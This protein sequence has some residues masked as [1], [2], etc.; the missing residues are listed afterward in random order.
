MRGFFKLTKPNIK[1]IFFF[2]M[3]SSALASLIALLLS[4]GDV[5]RSFLWSGPTAG[6]FPDFYQS[7]FYI[8]DPGA[9]YPTGVY[10]LL[11][12]IR[13]FFPYPTK[14]NW[15][16]FSVTPMGVIL[17]F[18][19][20][21]FI[22]LA[23]WLLMYRKYQGK[24]IEKAVFSLLLVLSTPF[25]YGIERGNLF[26]FVAVLI[27]CFVFGFD[28]PN[29]IIRELS[30]IAL[31]V[32]AMFKIYPAIFGILLLNKKHFH[33]A[34][35]CA[36]YGILLFFLPFLITDGL[37]GIVYMFQN[38]DKHIKNTLP[39]FAYAYR[40]DMSNTFGSIGTLLFNKG[41]AWRTIG[42]LVGYVYTA[43]A[44]IL[45]FYIRPYWKKM[46]LISTV[47]IL[48]QSFA[49]PYTILYM[50]PALIVFMNDRQ[51][52]AKT[53]YVY[54]ILFALIFALTPFGKSQD[55]VVLSSKIVDT[56]LSML[57]KSYSLLLFSI[58][59]LIEGIADV[60][61]CFNKPNVKC[62]LDT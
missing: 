61:H 48:T 17:A 31:A 5:S 28:H 1:S 27:M 11:N 49:P 4:R 38:I 30:L 60:V 16:Q 58:I 44:V 2:L 9:I 8:D 37:K 62:K 3:A 40:V 22:L 14:G 19:F 29:S 51:D 35:R 13:H 56:S 36:I 52:K 50:L 21:A 32:A 15:A 46:A 20:F 55:I 33:Q 34:V 59:L 7:V 41:N 12:I 26:M 47:A 54:S 24:M 10:W 53:D 23:L 42:T 57:I 39:K 6:V 18:Y 43:I 25:L 45:T